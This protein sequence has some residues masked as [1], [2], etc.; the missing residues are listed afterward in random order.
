MDNQNN[1]NQLTTNSDGTHQNIDD[2]EEIFLSGDLSN[3]PPPSPTSPTPDQITSS[4][5]FEVIEQTWYELRTFILAGLQNSNQ[6]L[7]DSA[8]LRIKND[9]E[10]WLRWE[11]EKIKGDYDKL[12]EEYLKVIQ[13]LKTVKELFDKYIQVRNDLVINKVNRKDELIAK[14]YSEKDIEK[15]TEWGLLEQ[16]FPNLLFDEKRIGTTNTLSVSSGETRGGGKKGNARGLS[17]FLKPH[18]R[19]NYQ[20]Y[21][22]DNIVEEQQ[23]TV[24]QLIKDLLDKSQK[25]GKAYKNDI[26]I[27]RV[28]SK[29]NEGRISGPSSGIAHYLALYSALNKVPLPR[30]LASTGTVEGNEVGVV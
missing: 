9:I 18:N 28:G 12:L 17:L 1:F 21:F 26:Y 16:D 8:R 23:N 20:V 24:K 2:I 6:P 29:E 11:L 14:G 15:L 30:N 7:I 10:K 25:L 3:Q 19:E 22:P 4:L 27:L 13:E 5:S